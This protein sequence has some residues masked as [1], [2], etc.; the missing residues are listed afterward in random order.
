AQRLHDDE[1][2]AEDQPDAEDAS[3]T[4]Q[5]PDYSE[6]VGVDEDEPSEE[7]DDVDME[8]DGDEEEEEHQL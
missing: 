2:V 6:M 1:I 4:A 8:A 5:S 3:P 7:D